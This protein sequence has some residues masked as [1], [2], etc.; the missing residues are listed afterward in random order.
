MDAGEIRL[1]A[2]IMVETGLG[3]LE[4]TW[5]GGSIKLVLPQGSHDPRGPRGRER[6]VRADADA[7]I[8][9]GGGVPAGGDGYAGVRDESS[10][11]VTVPSPMV[12]VF[13][14]APGEGMQPYVSLGDR[15][16]AGDILC[17]IESMKMM[18][19]I[20]AEIS[21]VVVEICASN[22]QAVDYGHPLFRMRTGNSE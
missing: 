10:N 17:V 16:K 9:P 4:Y 6:A 5:E 18:N 22:K 11:I 8:E 20:N 7:E 21:G 2:E 14:S 13:Y 12:G 3:R 15:V 1:L 19:E